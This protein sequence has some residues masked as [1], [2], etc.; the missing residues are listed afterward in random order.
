LQDAAQDF[1]D[2]VVGLRVLVAIGAR[3]GPADFGRDLD[4]V[5]SLRR[6]D[7]RLRPE[8]VGITR[9]LTANGRVG[10]D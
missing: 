5:R 2:L 3:Q 9:T 10:T 8:L 4:T 6:D 1:D 7:R